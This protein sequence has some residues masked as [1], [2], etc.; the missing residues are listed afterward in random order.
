MKI[1]GTGFS[2]LGM[3]RTGV[4]T[5]RLLHDLGADVLISD[6]RAKYR[7]EDWIAELPEGVG[8]ETDGLM[9]RPGDVV[10]ISPGISPAT[11]GFRLAQ[12]FGAEVISDIELFYRLWPGDIVAITGTDG[13]STVTSLTA[14]LLNALG[15]PA[16]TAGNIGKAVANV[17]GRETPDTIVVL[18][19]SSAQLLTTRGFRPKV[20]V[21]TN[22][23]EDHLGFHGSFD[24]YV[25]AKR[26]VIANQ[27][28]GDVFVRNIDD[29]IINEEFQPEGGQT[30]LDVSAR[31][32]LDDG[33]YF[34]GRE[35]VVAKRGERKVV[36]LREDL[37]LPGGYNAQNA[38]MAMGVAMGM[39]ID[40]T[41]AAKG[42][43]TFKGLK[44]R[45]EFVAEIR[46]VKFIN[47]SKATN[48][49]AAAAGLRGLDGRV[50]AIV[51]GYDKGLDFDAMAD[52]LREKVSLVIYTGP[53]GPRIADSVDDIVRA[54]AASDI[55]GAVRRAFE[56]ATWG[57]TVVLSPG[58]SS[59][60]AF[61]DFED[62][63]RQFKALVR[64]LETE[65]GQG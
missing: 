26:R 44:H 8:Y 52:A 50:I 2:I 14:H 51:G 5:A 23:A 65:N 16:I 29:P 43:R 19:V 60:D 30:V 12:R 6:D 31:M 13:K 63:G 59:F 62:R 33:V 40:L 64:G 36:A 47:D 56:E 34:S 4:A 25:I 35:F 57:D 28:T 55:E 24:A 17:P 11:K 20:A 10:V 54:E 58:C 61:A 39:G 21:V 27:M 37:R 7:L 48:P 49:H 32:K 15:H 45:M 1:D 18:E 22:I 41:D 46:G 9:V 53:A 3:A 42:L 38:L